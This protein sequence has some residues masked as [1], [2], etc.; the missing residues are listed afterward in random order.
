MRAIAIELGVP[1]EAIDIET[2]AA[3]TYDSVVHSATRLH[4]MGARRIL[5]VSSPY[6]M[7]RAMLVWRSHAP[8]LEVRAAPVPASAFYGDRRSVLP[9]HVGAIT[10]EYAALIYYRWKGYWR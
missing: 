3:T 10:H 1:P 7:R 2:R 4:A 6:H 9:Q 8:D 5:F